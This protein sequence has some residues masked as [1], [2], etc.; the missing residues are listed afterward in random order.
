MET[1]LL[2]LVRADVNQCQCEIIKEK[3]TLNYIDCDFFA[4]TLFYK[5]Q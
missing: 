2:T 5:N 4:I 1:R 3:P